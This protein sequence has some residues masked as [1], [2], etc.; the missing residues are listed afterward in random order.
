MTAFLKTGQATAGGCPTPPK[1]REDADTFCPHITTMPIKI[2]AG[3]PAAE[4]LENENIF[5]MDDFRA[6]HQDIRPLRIAVLNLMP[7]KI[8]TETQLIRLLSNTSL[9]IDLTLLHTI[10]HVSRHTAPE[11]M[12]LFYKN[13]FDV[14]DEKFDGLIITGAPVENLPFE[15]VDYWKELCCVMEWAKTNVFSTFHICWAAQAGLYYYYGIPKYNRSDKLFGVFS[16]NVDIPTDPIVRGFDECFYAPHSRHTEVHGDDIAKIPELDII[17]S[18]AEAGVYIIASKDKRRLFVTG[19]SEYD[20]DTLANE[21]FRDKNKGLDIQI[22]KNYFPD[23]DPEKTPLNLWRGHAHL[24]FSNWL[25]YYVYQL[26][27]FDL[28]DIGR[29]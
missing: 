5:V 28:N 15:Q 27:P 17:A 19:H 4:A 8:T 1:N 23:D 9:Q 18:S 13:F 12:R 29:S 22:P 3:L 10:S 26:T 11:H 20:R 16:H 21:Y 14:R 6:S 25:N 2:P 24:L 7:T